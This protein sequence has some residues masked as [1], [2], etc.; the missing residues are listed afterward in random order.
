MKTFAIYALC[1]SH[2]GVFFYGTWLGATRNEELHKGERLVRPVEASPTHLGKTE[3][4]RACLARD[5]MLKIEPLK[6]PY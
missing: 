6:G 1:I 2:A 3:C 5:R 4:V